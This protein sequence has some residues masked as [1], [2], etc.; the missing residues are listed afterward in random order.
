MNDAI[1]L[2]D[3]VTATVARG[4]GE[5]E[6]LV[7]HGRYTMECV[8][9]DGALKWAEA[10]DN[11]V[12]TAGKNLALDTFLAGSGYTVTG[13]YLGLISGT[14]YSATAAADTM[15]SHA[16]WLEAGGANAPTCSGNRGTCAWSA[17]S[18]GA[19]ALSAAASFAMTGAGSVQGAFLVFGAGAVA[20]KD[21]TAGTLFSAA[22]FTG[23]AKTVASGDTVNVSYSLSA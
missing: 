9:A 8:G 10:I 3:A 2:G 17:A 7:L 13:P 23:G 5:A 12:T 20:T 19:K 14:S 18:G 1:P 21:S 4:A 22:A 6:A 11:V 15:A 16:G